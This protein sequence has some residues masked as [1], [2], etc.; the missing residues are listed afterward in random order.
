VECELVRGDGG[1]F[2]VF[3]DGDLIFSKHRENRFPEST[4]IREALRARA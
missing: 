4:E 2:D 3:M 1:V